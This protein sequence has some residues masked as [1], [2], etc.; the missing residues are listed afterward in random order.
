M[1]R[2]LSVIA[3]FLV[4]ILAG[5]CQQPVAPGNNCV[6]IMGVFDPRA[7]GFIVGYQSGVDPIATTKQL[8]A[9]YSFS[10]SHVYTALPGFSAQLSTAALSGLRCE[11]T[12]SSISRDGVISIAAP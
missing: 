4:T 8:E 10:A 3:V 9:K 7:P 11:S 6:A 2:G 5:G 1:S 12:I